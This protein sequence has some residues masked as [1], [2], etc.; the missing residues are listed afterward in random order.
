M[1]TENKTSSRSVS[2]LLPLTS[3]D[4]SPSPPR[5]PQWRTVMQPPE[6]PAA[7][8]G[9]RP[10]MRFLRRVGIEFLA[11]LCLTLWCTA[12]SILA[13]C[14]FG[15]IGLSL[16]KKSHPHSPAFSGQGLSILVIGCF[17]LSV[18]IGVCAHALWAITHLQEEP[19]KLGSRRGHPLIAPASLLAVIAGGFAPALGI[20]VY[21]IH[22]LPLGYT[23]A[24]ALQLFGIGLGFAAGLVVFIVGIVVL[25]LMVCG[26]QTRTVPKFM[27]TLMIHNLAH[28]FRHLLFTVAIGF[29]AYFVMAYIVLLLS[30]ATSHNVLD[31]K[32]RLLGL[33]GF[34]TILVGP[35]PS[36]GLVVINYIVCAAD[37]ASL[38]IRP[39]I[40]LQSPGMGDLYVL[41]FSPSMKCGVVAQGFEAIILS[42]P[43]GYDFGVPFL[44]VGL[45]PLPLYL[46]GWIKK[47]LRKARSKL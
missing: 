27:P 9:P 13:S 8:T 17:I 1:F 21:P 36:S 23:A 32:P 14:V 35:I 38:S 6:R 30:I 20:V 28:Y 3:D 18:A 37:A 15:S 11:A 12:L 24:V 41:A 10:T 40:P 2:P 43:F 25:G 42:Q 7:P 29:V 4:L 19:V 44:I 22:V 45:L 47:M 34:Q 46:A 16:F 26:G 5:S 33:P 39:G 31:S